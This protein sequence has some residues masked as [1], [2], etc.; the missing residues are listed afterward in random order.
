VEGAFGGMILGERLLY[1]Y[2]RHDLYHLRG[3]DER[4]NPKI[5]DKAE[6]GVEK[7]PFFKMGKD[8]V[9]LNPWY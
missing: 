1:S 2:A 7:L 9:L 3:S 6:V 5:G 8:F 4:R